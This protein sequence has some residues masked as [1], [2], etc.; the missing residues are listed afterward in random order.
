MSPH[1]SYMS[2]NVIP[3]FKSMFPDNKSLMCYKVTRSF[4]NLHFSTYFTKVSTKILIICPMT[5]ILYTRF[6]ISI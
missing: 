4:I 6:G 1:N 2:T 5:N 3:D